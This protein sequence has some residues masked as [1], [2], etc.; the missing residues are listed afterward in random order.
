MIGLMGE[1][2]PKKRPLPFGL[3]ALKRGFSPPGR[4]YVPTVQIA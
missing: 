3:R 1:A 2:Y 4:S